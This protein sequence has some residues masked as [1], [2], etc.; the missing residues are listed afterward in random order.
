MLSRRR[1][2]AALILA[3]AT[4]ACRQVSPRPAVPTDPPSPAIDEWRATAQAMLNDALATLRTFDDFVAYRVS[5]TPSSGM[6]SA[7]SL[8]WDPPSGAAWD[9]ATHTSRGLHDRA[10]QLLQAITTAS[11]DPALWRT[12][13]T[14]ADATQD[15]INLGDALQAYRDR[16]DRLPPGDA[17]G[18]LDLLNRAWTQWDAVATRWDLTRTEAITC[19]G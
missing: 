9:S 4:A 12:Q 13:R 1:V 14:M 5:V 18:A 6:R 7:A 2:L 10:Y 17:S 8:L 3:G 15:I 19:Q 16:I 11:I